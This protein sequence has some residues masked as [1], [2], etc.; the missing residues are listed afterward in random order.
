MNVKIYN[1]KKL[2]IKNKKQWKLQKL[3]NKYSQK[4]KIF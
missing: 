2:F 1:N 4:H 3:K